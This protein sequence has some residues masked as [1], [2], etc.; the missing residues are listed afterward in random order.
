MLHPL[1]V[2]RAEPLSDCTN[3][4]AAE[5]QFCMV[6]L[7]GQKDDR[8]AASYLKVQIRGSE[9][10][11]EPQKVRVSSMQSTESVPVIWFCFV[12]VAQLLLASN[13]QRGSVRE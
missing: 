1:C 2:R 11:K 12:S 6:A 13:Q 3:V 8:A 7:K 10:G 9:A 4:C 5:L